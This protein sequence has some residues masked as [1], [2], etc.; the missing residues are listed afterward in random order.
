MCCLSF[1]CTS[2][3][4]KIIISCITMALS[5]PHRE[6]PACMSAH[7]CVYVVLA[8]CFATELAY[9]CC[10]IGR[11]LITDGGP[12]YFWSLGRSTAYLYRAVDNCRPRP[13]RSTALLHT[14]SQRNSFALKFEIGL[15][16]RRWW[17]AVERKLTSTSSRQVYGKEQ[18]VAD[19]V[20]VVNRL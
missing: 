7:V 11:L 4:A 12:I 9:S 14:S 15:I 1:T 18:T 3:P 8:F 6:K 20:K 19:M 17:R 2:L 16:G 5:R 13:C 10:R